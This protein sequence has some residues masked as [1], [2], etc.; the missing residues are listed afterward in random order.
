METQPD[1][2][3]ARFNLAMLLAG[4]GRG[5]EAV[6]QFQ[7]ALRLKPDWPEVQANLGILLYQQGQ[8]GPAVQHWRAFLR[9]Q[10]DHVAIL[11]RVAWVLATSPDAAVRNGAEA[12]KLALRAAQLSGRKTPAILD[13]LAAA[14]AETGQFSDAAA[15]CRRALDLATDDMNVPLIAVVQSHL[16]LYQAGKPLRRKGQ[17]AGNRGQGIGDRG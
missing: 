9:H 10:P 3:A 14:Y 13:T 12:L 5:G 16:K 11:N 2:P 1:W 6:E 17:G 4:R 7:A 8:E 15:V